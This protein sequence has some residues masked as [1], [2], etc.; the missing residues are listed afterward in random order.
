MMMRRSWL[1]ILV[2]FLLLAACVR[3]APSNPSFQPGVSTWTTVP[4]IPSLQNIAPVMTTTPAFQLLPTR[5]PGSPIQSPTPDAAHFAVQGQGAAETYTVQSGDTLGAIALAYGVTVEQIMLANALVNP[6]ALDVGQVLVIPIG[7]PQDAGPANKIIPDSELVY[8]PMSI[9]FDLEAFISQSGGYL[10]IFTQD[11]NGSVM[12]GAQI[13]RQVAQDFSVNPRLLLAVLE[14]RA[15]WVTNRNPNAETIETPLKVADG[16]HKGLYLQLAWAANTLSRGYY[17]WQVNG[18]QKWTLV[19]GSLV[20]A[21]PTLNAGTAGVQYLFSQQDVYA[22]WLLDVSENGLFATYNRLFGYPFDLAIEPVIPADLQQPPMQLPFSP[23]EIWA[24]TGGPHRGWSTGSAW[25]ALDF[26]PWEMQGCLSSNAWVV[27]VSD[28]L[29]V[30]AGNG[31]VVQDLDNDGYEQTG[32]TVLYLH[33]EDRDRVRA[34]TY[35]H[36]GERIGHPSCQGG[37]APATHLHLARRFN[38]EWIPADGS[39]PFNLDGWISSGTGIEYDG[40]LSRN[41]II[42][43]AYDGSQPTNQIQR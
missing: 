7:T 3:T 23:G 17:L 37:D 34:G 12:S 9:I 26:A 35:L 11:I 5:E 43:E 20:P 38:G 41:G 36:A 40:Y 24:F 28:G 15:G 32:W 33:V 1:P 29:I 10:S 25:A 27:A 14:Y 30:R 6:D 8:G 16:Y 42:L 21:S 4:L 31:S 19:D 39:V 2:V 13:V 18:A 22:A